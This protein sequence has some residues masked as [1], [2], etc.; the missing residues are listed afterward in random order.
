MLS[1]ILADAW[2]GIPVLA[3]SLQAELLTL[4]KDPVDAARIDGASELMIFC[5]VTLPASVAGGTRQHR[6]ARP[7]CNP[8][9]LM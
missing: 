9:G 2:S 1:V 8:R 6:F 5:Y 3:I 7:P 4:P